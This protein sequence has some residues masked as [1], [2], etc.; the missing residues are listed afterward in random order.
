MAELLS[1]VR[2]NLL[3]HCG[4]RPGERLLVAV[5][6]GVDSVVLLHVLVQLRPEF[7]WELVVAHYN[8]GLRGAES[9]ADAAFVRRLA[10]ELCLK[11]YCGRGPVRQR[12]SQ[13]GESIEMAA[14]QLRHE[15]LYRTALR[16]GAT[17]IALAHNA[18]DQ[19]ELFFLRTLRGAGG[20]GLAGMRWQAPSPAT[21]KAEAGPE[22]E[23]MLVRPLLDVP[24]TEIERYAAAH[25]IRFRTDSSNLS[26][27]HL[28]NWIRLEL[29][30]RL[31]ERFGTRLYTVIPRI[32]EIIGSES[33]F[34]TAQ[35]QAV[36]SRRRPRV[37]ARLPVAIQRQMLR[38]Q[39]I[40][41]GFTPDFDTIEKLRTVEST[42][43][44]IAAGTS[45]YRDRFGRLHVEHRAPAT[46]SADPDPA[47][48]MDLKLDRS[49]GQVCFHGVLIRWSILPVGSRKPQPVPGRVEYFDADA[50][51]NR[52]R[53]RHWRA[54][55]RFRPI[56]MP[57]A[58]KI[59]DLFVNNKVPREVRHRLV[60]AESETGEIFWVEG[61]R[62]GER[63]KVT[64]QTRRLL[65][66]AHERIHGTA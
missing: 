62:I 2:Q 57:T 32:M 60:L 64:P 34:V 52:I 47:N 54:G 23:I 13:T 66:W 22:P 40:D 41:S 11:C 17:K 45:V 58:A 53:L 56:G 5:S 4:V 48:T 38:L 55:D 51:G 29:I 26:T 30:P 15:F 9:D 35:A 42:P 7:G 25:N 50:V 19:V 59:Q 43:I 49:A 39:L 24:R 61:L 63:F 46:A 8:H 6:G 16:V 33:E 31:R 12:A 3:E 1:R 21:P 65:R 27:E 10:A 36:L 14:R 20:E 28:R 37:F 18:D 44:T